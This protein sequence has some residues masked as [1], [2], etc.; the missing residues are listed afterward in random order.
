MTTT[1]IDS[2]RLAAAEM[3]ARIALATAAAI[4]VAGVVLVTAVLPAEYGGSGCIPSAP[5]ACSG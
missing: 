3:R 2:E 5:V 4:F 1:I